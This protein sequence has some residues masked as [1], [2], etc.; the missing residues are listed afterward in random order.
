MFGSIPEIHFSFHNLPYQCLHQ[1][2]VV[3]WMHFEWTISPTLVFCW[4]Q[5]ETGGMI[6]IIQTL[7]ILSFPGLFL[8][9]TDFFPIF[10]FAMLM[11]LQIRS[12]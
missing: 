7:R 11:S 12:Y 5:L 2:S 8:L 3:T 1:A 9:T 4:L 6:S 10:W